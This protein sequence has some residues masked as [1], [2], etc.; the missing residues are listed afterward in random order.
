MVEELHFAGFDLISI[1]AYARP[2]LFCSVSIVIII[3]VE[4][5]F[6]AFFWAHCL[7]MLWVGLRRQYEGRVSFPLR[8][9]ASLGIRAIFRFSE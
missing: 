5:Q 4:L 8:N 9:C 6:R 1:I 3:A 2:G 7:G